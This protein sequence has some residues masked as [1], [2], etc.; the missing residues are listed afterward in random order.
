MPLIDL[1]AQTRLTI[2]ETASLPTA[3]LKSTVDRGAIFTRHEV[4]T[5]IL[6]LVGYTEDQPLF[7]KRILE[8]SFGEGAFLIP[9]IERL[10]NSWDKHRTSENIVTDLGDSICAVELDNETFLTTR[11]KIS[12]LLQNKGVSASSAQVL[13]QRWLINDDFLLTSVGGRFDFVVGNPPYVRQESIAPKL[14]AK[15]RKLY[16]TI[17]DRADL[18][19][20]FIERSLSLLTQKGE[21]GFICADRWMKNRYG[22]PLRAFVSKDF[23]LKV[24][25]DMMDT[26]AFESDVIAYPAITIIA[27]TKSKYTRIVF[28]PRINKAELSLLAKELLAKKLGA[29]SSIKELSNVAN[30]VE[31]WLMHSHAKIDIIRRLEQSLPLL[32]ETGCKVGIGVATGADKAFIGYF[33]KLRVEPSRKLP[34]GTTKDII[35]GKVKWQGLGVIN[36][37]DQNGELVDLKKFKKLKQYLHQRKEMIAGRHCAKKNPKNW[38]RTIDKIHPALTTTPKLLIPDIKGEA[39]VVY[40]SGRVYP[41]HNLYYITSREW[42]LRA[43]Q[44]VLLSSV[45]HAF[46]ET[47]STKMRGG[48]LRFQAQYLRRIRIPRWNDVPKNLRKALIQAAKNHDIESCNIA[49]AALYHLTEEESFILIS[50][51]P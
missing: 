9:I 42:D 20:P 41:H 34:L 51:K 27:R 39:N 44:A 21:L 24:Y 28:R 14:M 15:Y 32:E 13:T 47:Y 8:P 17:Y 3:Y 18:Y 23:H 11:R 5:F 40:D 2:L 19:I 38:Y 35:S 25:I 43:L 10:I 30:G 31:P 26:R 22:G 6:D 33:D 46:I 4:V 12:K 48:Y 50:K 16:P 1:K 7:T 29:S 37:F 36:P 45:T 49:V